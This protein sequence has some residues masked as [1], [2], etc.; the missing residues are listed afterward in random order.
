[1]G[2]SLRA[3]A[4]GGDMVVGPWELGGVASVAPVAVAVPA[5]VRVRA[6]TR[7]RVLPELRQLL[8]ASQHQPYTLLVLD[9]MERHTVK[10]SDA[11]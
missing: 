8:G 3:I 10:C 7:L 9:H 4:D 5:A 6:L 1:M 2:E 11:P